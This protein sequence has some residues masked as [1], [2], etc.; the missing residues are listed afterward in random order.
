MMKRY[1]AGYCPMGCGDSLQLTDYGVIV[2]AD[3]RCPN[4]T[5]AARV[6]EENETEH[7]ATFDEDSFTLRHPLR[8]RFDG[9]LDACRWHSF[10][11]AYDRPPFGPGQYR[12]TT[13]A[14][15]DSIEW[16]TV[17]WERVS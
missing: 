10:L 16:A 9:Q 1:V 5:A 2:C 17:R 15:P 11:A 14:G 4:R 6:L 3:V 12:M 7:I 13:A 8:E